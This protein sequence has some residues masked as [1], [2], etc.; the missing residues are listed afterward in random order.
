M[1]EKR[2]PFLTRSKFRVEQTFGR[3]MFIKNFEYITRNFNLE[4]LDMSL[5]KLCTVLTERSF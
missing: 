4:R 1:G 3:I 2:Q 5:H